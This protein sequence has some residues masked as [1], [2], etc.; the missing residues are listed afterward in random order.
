MRLEWR[1]EAVLA[2][3]REAAAS[4]LNDA[5]EIVSKEW[6]NTIP[7]ATGELASHVQPMKSGELEYNISSTGPY[8][9]RQELDESLRH[10]DPTNPASRSGRK[11]H[12]GRD[13][14]DGNRD[15]IE[16][17]VASRVKGVL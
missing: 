17:L 10:P 5:A 6:Q 15:N 7:Y 13:S 1:G 2:K 14:L 11:A 8:A 3:V 12:A 16:K 4:G 9:R